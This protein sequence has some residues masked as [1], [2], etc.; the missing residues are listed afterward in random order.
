MPERETGWR[1]GFGIRTCPSVMAT[2]L[3]W[4]QVLLGAVVLYYLIESLLC[5]YEIAFYVHFVTLLILFAVEYVRTRLKKIELA[6]WLVVAMSILIV[7][8]NAMVAG[9]GHSHTLWF[10]PVIPL[11][12]GQLL[13]NRALLQSAA[14]SFLA[15]GAVMASELLI[16]IPS[17]Y[18]DTLE[19]VVA[20]RLAV[21]VVCGG[22]SISAKRT[23][24]CQMNQLDVQAR[25]LIDC[26]IERDQARRSASVFLAGMSEHIREPMAQLVHRTAQIKA[27]VPEQSAYLARD[28]EHCALRLTR[29]V[30]DILDLSDL[31]NDRLELWPSTFGLFEFCASVKTWFEAQACRSMKLKLDLPV[32]DLLLTVDKKRLHQICT[33]LLENAINFS[34]AEH[35]VLSMRS[36]SEEGHGRSAPN[37]MLRVSDDGVGVSCALQKQVM[38]RFAFYCDTQA[39]QDKGAGLSLVLLRQLAQRMGGDVS[40]DQRS[41]QQGTCVLVQLRAEIRAMP[42]FAR[43]A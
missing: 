41:A 9:Q 24:R 23:S 16:E 40:F 30:H 6:C 5:G 31:E 39:T 1:A 22:V 36:V 20:L 32:E 21:L 29:L 34:Q 12:A 18:P 17:E 28:A 38:E 27:L 10:F 8:A 3:R 14:A 2:R 42:A 25:E 43:A 7:S 11:M 26:R 13:G 4:V 37:L 15:V 35:L 19:D 33:R